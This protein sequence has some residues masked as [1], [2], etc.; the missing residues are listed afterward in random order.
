MVTSIR[1]ASRRDR[2]GAFQRK[3]IVDPPNRLRYW[4]TVAGL[5]LESLQAECAARGTAVHYISLMKLERTGLCVRPQKLQ[6]VIA[7]LNEYL[8]SRGVDYTV[9]LDD[10]YTPPT[11][12]M[13]K[14]MN[15]I[16][17]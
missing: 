3:P 13:V 9:T 8:E 16:Q 11:A 2:R 17:E 10:M 6:T 1:D 14:E 5:S 15:Q 12:G 4:R 7:V